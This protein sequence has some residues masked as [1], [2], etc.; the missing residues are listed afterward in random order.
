MILTCLSDNVQRHA[1][2]PGKDIDGRGSTIFLC[3][4]R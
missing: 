3:E 1:S 4:L 2:Q